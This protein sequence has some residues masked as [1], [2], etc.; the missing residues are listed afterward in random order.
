MVIISLNIYME[1]IHASLYAIFYYMKD[2]FALT[3][4]IDCLEIVDSREQLVD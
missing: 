2:L 4:L 3:V 1:S